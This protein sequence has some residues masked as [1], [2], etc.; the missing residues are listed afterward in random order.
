VGESVYEQIAERV[1]GGAVDLVGVTITGGRKVTAAGPG[2]Y[3]TPKRDIVSAV[4]VAVQNGEI[5]AA[6]ELDL[7]PTLR[8]EMESFTAEITQTGQDTY[9]ARQGEHDDLVLA[10]AMPLWLSDWRRR[11]PESIIPPSVSY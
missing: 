8:G 10:L 3:R 2:H 11:R 7:W 1:R 9:E 4:Q 6:S 5:K